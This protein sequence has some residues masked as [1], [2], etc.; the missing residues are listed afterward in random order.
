M[1]DLPPASRPART[2]ERLLSSLDA[3]QGVKVK[4]SIVAGDA[5]LSV[6]ELLALAQGQVLKL[7]SQIETP[8]DMCV[9][10]HVVARGELVAVDDCFGIRVVELPT[11]R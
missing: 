2:G 4:V 8:F 3:V 10:G 9:E 11:P 7:D 6:S 5:T 1:I